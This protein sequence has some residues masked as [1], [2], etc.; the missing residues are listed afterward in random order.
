MCLP[1]SRDLSTDLSGELPRLRRV[2]ATNRNSG[3]LGVISLACGRP[4]SVRSLEGAVMN[5]LGVHSQSG[6]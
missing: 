4:E 1:K 2:D 5:E 3:I 6:G